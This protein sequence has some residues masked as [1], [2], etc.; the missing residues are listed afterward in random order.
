MSASKKNKK[1]TKKPAGFQAPQKYSLLGWIALLGPILI[2]SFLLLLGD[3][4]PF[5]NKQSADEAKT[6]AEL[7]TKYGKAYLKDGDYQNA[8]GSFMRALNIKNDYTEAHIN[9]SQI[10]H[11]NNDIP[12]AIEWL[13]KALSFN[14]PQKDLIFNNMGLLYARKGDYN[15]AVAMFERALT[16]M[17]NSEEVYNNLGTV[18]YSFGNYSKAI[19][20]YKLALENRPSLKSGYIES[21]RRAIVEFYDD[22]EFQQVSKTAE[23]QLNAGISDDDLA[24]YDSEIIKQYGRSS[25]R[26]SELLSNLARALEMNGEIDSAIESAMKALRF[27][28]DSFAIHNQLG[29]LYLQKSLFKDA[30]KHLSTSLRLN[31]SQPS[32]QTMLENIDRLLK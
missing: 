12:K 23:K 10:Y 21:L 3:S 31:P 24:V 18:N 22:R 25:E 16:A 29:N 1:K 8:Y 17:M 14:P 28:P 7:L 13:E 26:E 5:L 11:I 4:I 30:R 15:T 2:I 6:Q 19:H 27:S 9:I 20:Y 32:I